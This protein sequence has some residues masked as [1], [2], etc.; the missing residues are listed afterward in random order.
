MSQRRDV[1]ANHERI[2]EAARRLW[3][4]GSAPSLESVAEAAGIGVATL[5]RHFANRAA[6][7]REVFGRVF[8]EELMPVIARARD[9]DVDLVTTLDAV[10]EVVGRYAPVLH[11]IGISEAT[12]EA[13]RDLGEPFITLLADGQRAGVLRPDLEPT[14]LFWVLRMLVLGLASPLSSPTVRRRY[15]A[16]VIPSLTDRTTP[17]PRLTEDDYDRLGVE[18][19]DRGPGAGRR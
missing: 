14:D 15:L 7:E 5:Y 17:L 3:T 16:L 10:V 18:P 8:T 13:L 11:A 12:D 6:L 9:A 1:A 4:E 19:Q 2:I